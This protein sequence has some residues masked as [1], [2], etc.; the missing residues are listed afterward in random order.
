MTVWIRAEPSFE[1]W[2]QI[3]NIYAYYIGI[4]ILIAASVIVLIVSFLGCCSA[5]MEHTSALFLVRFQNSHHL[6]FIIQNI[7]L[8][9]LFI[10]MKLVLFATEEN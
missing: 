5:L 7:P 9:F 4:Y 3:L 2:V 1:E 8:T 6:R 10:K